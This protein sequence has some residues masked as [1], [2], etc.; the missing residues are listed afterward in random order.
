MGAKKGSV[1]TSRP[2]SDHNRATPPVDPKMMETDST[3]AKV[4]VFSIRGRD[5]AQ[6]QVHHRRGGLPV[7]A[8]L[9]TVLCA[10]YINLSG[11]PGE[12]IPAVAMYL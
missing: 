11:R 8:W 3:V 5:E 1:F 7:H 10:P 6:S 4:R 12:K 2:V 9:Y